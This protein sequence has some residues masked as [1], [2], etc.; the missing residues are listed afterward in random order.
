MH[1]TKSDAIWNFLATFFK[2]ASNALLLP[3]ILRLLPSEE[4][5]LYMIFLS[6]TFLVTLFDFGFSASF[7]R[8]L[9][10]IFSGVKELKTEGLSRFV[11]PGTVDYSLLKGTIASMKWLYLR[12]SVCVLL[13]LSTAGTFYIKVVLENYSGNRENAF[14]AW[15]ILCLINSYS[16]Y[17]YYYDSLLVGIGLIKRSKQIIVFSQIIFLVS[18]SI[19]LLLGYGL[20][21]IVSSQLIYVVISR[22]LCRKVFFTK[23]MRSNLNRA[24]QTKTSE[25]LRSIT[26][27]AIKLG[28]TIF[29]GILVQRSSIFIGSLF[30]PLSD[31]ASYGLTR[32]I[33]DIMAG[34]APVFVSTYI[35]LISKYRV[36]GEIDKI[37]SIYLKG[38]LISFVVFFAGFLFIYLFGNPILIYLN[39]DTK[40]L[41]S[42][43]I[44]AVMTVTFLEMNHSSAAS[45]LLTKNEVPFFIPSIVSGAITAFLLFLFLKF[46]D[47]GLLSLMI[48]PGI[49][50]IS[51]QSWKWPLEVIK[52]LRISFSDVAGSIRSLLTTNINT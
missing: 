50:D 28:L 35:P 45:I 20:I 23:Q 5:G 39:S 7:S 8:N 19:L 47:L 4:V 21:A 49:V 31:I 42:A 1:I 18:A 24:L 10:Y 29:G 38:T 32:Q 2:A 15:G 44:I 14:I 27:N 22:S 43:L 36:E 26:P 16:L 12:I 40:L 25:V 13:I 6:V 17:T 52:D 37:K 51:Y 11:E 34:L 3:L 46:T 9:A 48:A 41:S 30:L 33:F